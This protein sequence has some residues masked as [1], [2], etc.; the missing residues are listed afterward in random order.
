MQKSLTLPFVKGLCKKGSERIQVKDVNITNNNRL[1]DKIVTKIKWYNLL[2][3]IKSKF[4]WI[5]I[6]ELHASLKKYEQV[7]DRNIA[8][9]P[10]DDGKCAEATHCNIRWNRY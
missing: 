3:R 1:L 8:S 2:M 5:K 10:C 7:L 6:T 9:E 4:T